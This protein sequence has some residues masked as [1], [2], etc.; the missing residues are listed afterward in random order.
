MNRNDTTTIR[1]IT[2]Y[3]VLRFGVPMIGKYVNAKESKNVTISP[4]VPGAQYRITAWALGDVDSPENRRSEKPA[5]ESTVTEEASELHSLH[6]GMQLNLQTSKVQL[7]YSTMVI[8][9][10]GLLTITYTAI[11]LSVHEIHMMETENAI[12]HHQLLQ[13]H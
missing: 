10:H 4:A 13:R 1:V 2:G 7:Q 11:I 6:E 3:E 8:S 9:L 5:V 12:E